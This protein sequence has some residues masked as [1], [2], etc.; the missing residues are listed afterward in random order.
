[1]K[2][3]FQ[4]VLRPAFLETTIKLYTKNNMLLYYLSS[5]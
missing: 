5:Y 4:A 1:M 2:Y 3:T